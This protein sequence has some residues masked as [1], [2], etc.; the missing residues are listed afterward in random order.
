MFIIHNIVKRKEQ[1]NFVSVEKGQLH[2]IIRYLA[3]YMG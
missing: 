2:S 1:Y 3:Y